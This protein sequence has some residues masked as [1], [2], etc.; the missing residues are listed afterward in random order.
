MVPGSLWLATVAALYFWPRSSSL[1]AGESRSWRGERTVIHSRRLWRPP[2]GVLWQLAAAGLATWREDAPM[3]PKLKGE[4]G[5]ADTCAATFPLE[6]LRRR[7]L[8]ATSPS[9]SEPS[10]TCPSKSESKHPP[11][12]FCPTEAVEGPASGAGGA[13]TSD[14]SPPLRSRKGTAGG[15]RKYRGESGEHLWRPGPASAFCICP[16][17]RAESKI[18][19]SLSRG[20]GELGSAGK[21][22]GPRAPVGRYEAIFVAGIAG[23]RRGAPSRRNG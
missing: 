19:G 11:R 22:L 9:E 3:L 13:S 8:L 14:R 21:G 2:S 7:S 18:Q 6:S 20:G 4:G 5:A 12:R 23:T 1:R 15:F 16:W 10:F 17:G